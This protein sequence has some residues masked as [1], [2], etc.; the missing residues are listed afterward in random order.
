MDVQQDSDLN[1]HPSSETEKRNFDRVVE[2][3]EINNLDDKTNSPIPNFQLDE[4]IDSST[5]PHN[6][7]E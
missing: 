7:Y 1:K 3:D 4:R 2:D 6:K 5:I